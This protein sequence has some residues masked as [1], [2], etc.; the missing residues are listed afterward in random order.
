MHTR[1]P[2]QTEIVL[3]LHSPFVSFFA[4]VCVLVCSGGEWAMGMGTSGSRL[5]MKEPA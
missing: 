5:E 3:L 2:Q 4:C 1:R